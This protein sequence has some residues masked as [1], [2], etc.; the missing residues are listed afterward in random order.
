MM[1]SSGMGQTAS[2]KNGHLFL[3]DE[4]RCLKLL[5]FFFSDIGN[6]NFLM[7]FVHQKFNKNYVKEEKMHI[8]YMTYLFSDLVFEKVFLPFNKKQIRRLTTKKFASEWPGGQAHRLRSCHSPAEILTPNVWQKFPM[9]R[10]KPALRHL[11]VITSRSSYYTY[12]TVL[13][14]HQNK[15]ND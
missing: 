15:Q 14:Y 1:A 13:R 2:E 4:K 6:M 7:F 10:S 3:V 11:D 12:H 5:F 8:T 9:V